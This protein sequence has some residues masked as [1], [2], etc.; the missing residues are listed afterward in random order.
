MVKQTIKEV[1]KRTFLYDIIRS[2]R[3]R[4]ASRE[5]YRDWLKAGKPVP[6]PHIVKQRAVREY[7]RKY[8][9]RVFVET[10]T[11][12]GDM[13]YAIKDYFD[14][15]YSI[16]LGQ[17]LY[18]RAKKRFAGEKHIAIFQ[19]D[20]TEIL[21]E[22]LARIGEPCLFWL[23][24]HYSEGIT[25]RGPKETPLKDELHHILS[26]RVQDHVILID[27][28]REFTDRDDYPSLQELQDLVASMDSSWVFEVK[29][30]I[31]RLFK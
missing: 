5:A 14:E 12:A 25:S 17:E 19:G 26:H 18:E 11:L 2:Y 24:A 15:I 6:P 29:D 30:D 9:L 13:I 3:Q 10:G 22:V 28:A 31:I 27:D 8:E 16:E 7:A 20:S 4:K 21:P 23:D 1:V